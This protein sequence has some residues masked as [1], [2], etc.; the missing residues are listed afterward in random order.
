MTYGA[1]IRNRLITARGSGMEEKW[2]KL[3]RSFAPHPQKLLMLA[4]V[5]WPRALHG[6][7]ACV[8][9]DNYLTTLRRAAVKALKIA[10]AGANPALRL[11]LSGDLMNDPGFYQLRYCLSTLRR[12]A[13]KSPDILP[14]WKLWHMTFQGKMLPGPFSKLS[15]CL[16]QIGWGVEHPPFIYDHE[17]HTWN[18]LT[19]DHKT[20][21]LLLEDAWFQ[22]LAHT[23]NHKT[24][25]DLAGM[26]GYLTTFQYEK[27]SALE[28]TL[29]SALQSGAFVSA[30]EHS[31][32]DATKQKDC[33]LCGCPDTRSHWLCCP[34]FQHL[35]LAIDGWHPDNV[36]LPACVVH[37]L[38]IPRLN[39]M[40]NWRHALLQIQDY[41]A[42][43]PFETWA[44]KW[45]N[46]VDEVVTRWN[47]CRPAS[48]MEQHAALSR[49]LSWWLER[50]LQ[51]RAFFFKVAEYQ[52]NCSSDAT[53]VPD[54]LSCIE[55]ESSASE[56]MEDELLS[57]LLPLNWR[58]RCR[59]S[60]GRLPGASFSYLLAGLGIGL[61]LGLL[62]GLWV[63]L[64][65]QSLVGFAL[66]EGPPDL[67]VICKNL[68]EKNLKEGKFSAL[69][70]A[71]A[72]F[73]TGFWIR[74]AIETCTPFSNSHALKG[75]PPAQWVVFRGALGG[76]PLRSIRKSD[77][78]KALWEDAD[79]I[80]L[81][82]ASLTELHIVC[83][84]AGDPSTLVLSLISDE[85]DADRQHFAVPIALREGG[86]LLAVPQGAL[87]E[88]TLAIGQSADEDAAV[89]P[90]VVI[91]MELIEEDEDL[92]VVRTGV[93][94]PV[95]CV[96]FSDGIL[97][98]LR[99]YDPVTDSQ[100]NI[101][102]FLVSHPSALPYV[103]ASLPDVFA[104]AEG[105]AGRTNFY[106][107]REEQ[108]DAAAPKKAATAAGKRPGG[109]PKRTTNALLAEQVQALS[110]Q[111]AMLME[112]QKLLQKHILGEASAKDASAPN[113]GG[114]L[115]GPKLP[116]LSSALSPPKGTTLGAL[117]Q[118]LGP[119]RKTKALH[120]GLGISSLGLQ[121]EGDEP[122]NPLLETDPV[123]QDPMLAALTQQ[124]AAV[125]ALVAHLAGG[126]D[127]MTD[128]HGGTVGSL[129]ASTK[130]LQRRQKL[131]TDL[132]SNASTFF[133]QLHQQI[134][135]K[136]HPA[137]A[138]PLKE[139]DLLSGQVGMCNYLERF[140]NFK[141]ARETGLTLWV[142][143][144]AIDA[145]AQGNHSLSRE[146]MALLALALEQAATDGDWRIAYHLTLLEDPPPIMFQGRPQ[147]VRS[148]SRL[149]LHGRGAWDI[150]EYLGDE[151]VMV[152]RDP[153]I[154]SLDVQPSDCPVIHDSPEEIRKLAQLWDAHGL[155]VAHFDRVGI[156]RPGELVR[157]FNTYKNQDCDRQIGD[158]RGRNS[159][160]ARV[161]GPSKWLPAGP[162]LQ[163]LLVDPSSQTV[164][165]CATDRR[166]F[167]HQLWV[168]RSKALCNTV[169]PGVP[170]AWLEETTVWPQLLQLMKRQKYDR[171][172]HGDLLG[173]GTF[174]K[175]RK[176]MCFDQ[177]WI[178]FGS[179]FQGDHAGVDLAT[180]GHVQLLKEAGLL[181]E[182]SRVQSHTPLRSSSL[183]QGLCIDDFFSIS[184]EETGV[185]AKVTEA[186]RCLEKAREVYEEKG[187]L[188]SPDKDVVAAEEG[189]VI[190]AQINASAR[191]RKQG[192]V[193]L[194]VPAQK[195]LALSFVTLQICALG[196]TTDALHLCLVG[197]W[198]SVL[199]YR[200][201]LSFVDSSKVDSSR[202]RI[203][204]LP[205]KL[206]DE[207]VLLSVLMPLATTELSAGYHEWVY[208]TDASSH[209]GAAVKCRPEGRT[210]EVLWKSCRSKGSYT[211]FRTQREILLRRLGIA[212]E[213][214]EIRHEEPLRRPLAFRFDFI[215]V[216]SGASGITKHVASFGFLV[217]PC[218]DLSESEEYNV[219]YVHVASW[220]T[221]LCSAG[222]L[223]GFMLEPPCTT[224]SIMRR[225]QLRSLQEPFGFDPAEEQTALGTRLAQ[226]SFQVMETGLVNEVPG[227]LE[228]PYSSRMK[229]LPSY[230]A[231]SSHEA[232]DMCR[233]VSCR[234]GSPHMK[235]FRFL[236]VHA[237]LSRLAKRCVCGKKHLL[238]QGSL[239]KAS[240]TYTP[241]LSLELARTL[242]LAMK[243]KIEIMEEDQAGSVV[244]LENLL[245]NQVAQTEKWEP[246]F[247][248]RFKRQ[249]HI[250]I[251]ELS[252][253]LRLVVHLAKTAAHT[254]VV[255]LTD[256]IVVRG[257]VSKGRTSSRGLSAVLRK[258]CSCVVAAGLYITVPFVPTRLNVADD[259]TREAEI[260]GAAGEKVGESAEDLFDM[261]CFPP[262]RRWAANW[263]RFLLL[264]LGPEAMM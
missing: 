82:V 130:G 20:L 127:A 92:N 159:V 160:E 162:D 196:Y 158:R 145:S 263:A 200:R 249:S 9:A 248:W 44:F 238:V 72:A 233:T 42:C 207:L 157:V 93:V 61:C 201:P 176:S 120:A 146:F 99:E 101:K 66:E 183:A 230:K 257:A 88:G 37:H 190:G 117:A 241:L 71:E 128:L 168:T 205:R 254:R 49:T 237:P 81:P 156:D 107:G 45:N 18:L 221:Y 86:L 6:A 67:P 143:W 211:R 58:V 161:T 169:G 106:R 255:C 235:P 53:P 165:I 69:Q 139:E 202:P 240:A 186:E 261:A 21:S 222:H 226:R 116:S 234:F 48:F 29:V 108:A 179:V 259:P 46:V 137:K 103:E 51:L 236:S 30:S 239:T 198:V 105:A 4:R 189:K 40:V 102:S 141:M 246:L 180:E 243:V 167:Y 144:H 213:T 50:I 64:T 52:K 147:A 153:K 31:K 175:R 223:K 84:G 95:V 35:R 174:E 85:G 33:H 227:I 7:P 199:M 138:V 32:F 114:V 209:S 38:L 215:E 260:R 195:K 218:I 150:T 74:I 100:E 193:T 220:L 16:A 163:D 2:K 11:S 197:A 22:F 78:V 232:S 251:L 26:D 14:L 126:G 173:G 57:D 83:A 97:S 151:L 80:L 194:G 192:L 149:V 76:L 62:L 27:L 24:M 3:K 264:V 229:A 70:R 166:D 60:A 17:Q 75:L 56:Q 212:E 110:G 125:T 135:R 39:E 15:T 119:P 164:S 5:F 187:L 23:T 54:T 91:E 191:A 250:N 111:M 55:V 177:C 152:Y 172:Q 8:F 210:V 129:G 123:P 10:G 104:C 47:Q 131:Q 112:S 113:P 154:L 245:V 132:S 182:E 224:F 77:C 1:K 136:M 109:G 203:M 206:K 59:Q 63:L 242:C 148:A 41:Q 68:A 89:G 253:V 65:L 216:F 170:T 178:A 188:G 94:A 181:Q 258:I 34:R 140:G 247:S 73:K 98:S 219:E 134:Y 204:R 121:A 12:L 28:R 96:D 115:S 79:S 13:Q 171:Q 231:L 25:H 214:E 185:S 90:S 244:G 133:L 43:D 228:T 217:G 142:L 256:S 19:M 184:V 118:A 252:S 124:S 262:M 87:S 225:P 155:L 208:A 36:E 122:L